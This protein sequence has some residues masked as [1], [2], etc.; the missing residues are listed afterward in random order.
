M[1]GD[2][3]LSR[4][5]CLS[6]RIE[7]TSPPV[8]A[9]DLCQYPAAAAG[10]YCPAGGCARG[11]MP[12]WVTPL[13]ALPATGK[14]SR[15]PPFRESLPRRG[16]GC[17]TPQ[18][19]LPARIARLRNRT[20]PFSSGRRRHPVALS[21]PNF[22]T[23]ELELR[24]WSCPVLWTQGRPRRRFVCLLYLEEHALGLLT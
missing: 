20:T 16:F 7:P 12:S 10:S 1:Y 4:P 13:P 17:P 15:H 18:A 22:R 3:C 5:A 24:N 19:P 6:D 2:F 8:A 11:T 9:G 21:K 14:R 23:L